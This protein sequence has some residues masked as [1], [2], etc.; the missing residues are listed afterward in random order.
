MKNIFS[1]VFNI[2]SPQGIKCIVC[3]D[4]LNK[5]T[6]HCVCD[7]CFDK[8]PFIAKSCTKCGAEI[9]SKSSLCIECKDQQRYFEKAIS[10]FNFE[11]KIASLIYRFKYGNQTYL[12]KYL[13]DFMFNKVVEQN[14][15]FD[16][17]VPVPLSDKRLKLR[18]FNQAEL[19]AAALAERFGKPLVCDAIVRD[20]DTLTQTHLSKLERHQNLNNAFKVINKKLIK[21][22][23]ILLVD[24]VFTTGTTSDEISKTLLNASS[25]SVY[26]ITFAHAVNKKEKGN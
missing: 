8:L 1:K 10:V 19:L 7:K 5:T 14:L 3:D 24:D 26:V 11:D 9:Y 4:E 20:R 23:K 21:G 22:K 17:I 25:N 12:A 18:T 13:A 16:I 2:I 6:S 15:D